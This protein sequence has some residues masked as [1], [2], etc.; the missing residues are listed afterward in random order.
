M[1]ERAF[2]ASPEFDV[3]TGTTDHHAE[4]AGLYHT[5]QA[6]VQKRE[7]AEPQSA[8]RVG[9]RVSHVVYMLST[10]ARFRTVC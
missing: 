4:R 7:L 8:G 5:V 1:R 9:Q 3:L 6:A 10:N 2:K